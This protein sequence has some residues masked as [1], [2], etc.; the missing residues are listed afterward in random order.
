MT[1]LQHSGW[2][3]YVAALVKYAPF[4]MLILD[5]DARVL[6]ANPSAVALLGAPDEEALVGM[7]LFGQ[8]DEGNAQLVDLMDVLNAG[9]KVIRDFS[10]Q[11]PFGNEVNCECTCVPLESAEESGGAP[12]MLLYM[13]DINERRMREKELLRAEKLAALDNM[14]AGVAHELNNPL[15][16]VLGYTEMLLT[17][18]LESGVRSRLAAVNE[19]AERCRK[20]VERLLSFS[21]P[22]LTPK[23]PTSLNELLREAEQ[24]CA[25]QMRVA[26][27]T[28]SLSLDDAV[29]LIPL[30]ERE[31][32]RVFLSIIM[33][34]AYAL[35]LVHDRPRTLEISSK[36]LGKFVRVTFK[37]NGPGVPEEIRDKIFD[38]FFTTK[39]IGEG[40]GMG[41]SVA[42]GIMQQHNGRVQLEPSTGVGASFS[43]D[44]PVE[45]RV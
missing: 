19:Y 30:Q 2:T 21:T 15:V 3:P 17:E 9:E 13:R 4:G 35:K 6:H 18:Q 11:G 12:R 22:H 43:L 8:A 20:I 38:P 25:Y 29:P 40:M 23:V 45:Q 34:A 10:W 32:Q 33:N 28:L 7:K 41:L 16:V 37:D 24:L 27:I 5:K 36:L 44:I 39:D 31:V 14:I 42:Y 26:G 1:D